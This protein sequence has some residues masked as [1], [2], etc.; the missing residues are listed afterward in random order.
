MR[1]RERDVRDRRRRAGGVPFRHEDALPFR[2]GDV[3]PSRFAGRDRPS[4]T[5]DQKL[6]RQIP[7]AFFT[8]DFSSSTLKGLVR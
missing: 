2:H 4:S 6:G 3:L 7:I 5:A 1:A 8:F